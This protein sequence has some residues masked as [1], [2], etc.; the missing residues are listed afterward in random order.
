MGS[1]WMERDVQM[2][3]RRETFFSAINAAMQEAAPDCTFGWQMP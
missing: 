2:I 3:F 1:R